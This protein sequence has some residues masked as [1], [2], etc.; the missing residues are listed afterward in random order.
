MGLKTAFVVSVKIY[1]A[2]NMQSMC[3]LKAR[4]WKKHI[5]G[6]VCVAAQVFTKA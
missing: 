3:Q 1:D 4:K 6:G 5:I 2:L